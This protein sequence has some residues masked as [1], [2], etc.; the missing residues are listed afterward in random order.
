MTRTRPASSCA[1]VC[2]GWV[3]QES[4]PASPVSRTARTQ[5]GPLPSSKPGR[6]PSSSTKRSHASRRRNGSSEAAKRSVTSA[7]LD[8]R[9]MPAP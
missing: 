6:R 4:V 2:S 1:K 9:S 8:A 7:L 3:G 5:N